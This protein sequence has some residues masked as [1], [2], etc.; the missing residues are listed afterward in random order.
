GDLRLTTL[1]E[2]E[3]WALSTESGI[4]YFIS[5][6]DDTEKFIVSQATINAA[7]V[8]AA[9]SA[10]F[11]V[12][13]SLR[14]SG[15]GAFTLNTVQTNTNTYIEN[16]T[17]DSA[18]AV[19]LSAESTS[20]IMAV[21]GAISASVSIGGGG[22]AGVSLGSAISANTIG[23]SWFGEIAPSA[24]EVRA[25]IKNSSIKAVG[26][27]SLE[28]TAGQTI[29]AVVLSGSA[30][31][32]G[33]AG[34]GIAGSGS[35]VVAL[36]RIGVVVEASITGDGA[37]GIEASSISLTAK[38]V[39]TIT[40]LAGA[41]SL[42]VSVAG[43]AGVSVSIG[44]SLAFNQISSSVESFIFQADDLVKTT[45]GDIRLLAD[46][47]ATINA[48]SSAASISAG[49]AVGASVRISGAG[50]DAT[51]I[52]LTK[53]NAYIA[54]SI[55]DSKGAVELDSNSYGAINAMIVSASFSASIGGA[56]AI[57]A[58]LGLALARNFIGFD[59]GI[60]GSPKYTTSSVVQTISSGETVKIIEGVRAGDIY[61]YVG[62]EPLTRYEFTTSD[63]EQGLTDGKRVLVSPDYGGGGVEGIYEYID[64]PD[65]LNL[66]TQ[67]YSDTDIWALIDADDLTQQ[68]YGD[69][70]T[71]ELD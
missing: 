62:E 15:A 22:A 36:N 16:S 37:T 6:D 1:S 24:G 41:A 63:G 47:S 28:A 67:D 9:V 69:P 33:G 53:T 46:G 31:V 40:A 59:V 57:G 39:S 45:T 48:I 35:G 70:D 30:A 60:D 8:A 4:T 19:S 29:G 2:G 68:D 12:G 54:E 56:A 43:A 42:A 66:G 3:T 61:K 5:Y 65:T 27:L 21:T 52:I 17:V 11:A 44:V 51:N 7:A 58:S 25:Y 34:A 38:D 50:A 71:W 14:V 55:I 49:F 18:D 26:A 20:G 10:G 13:A 23:Y 64:D 32:A